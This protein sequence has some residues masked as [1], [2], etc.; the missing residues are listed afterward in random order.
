MELVVT[1]STR[2]VTPDQKDNQVAEEVKESSQVT[3]ESRETCHDTFFYLDL[4]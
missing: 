4:I 2:L 1:K 3:E